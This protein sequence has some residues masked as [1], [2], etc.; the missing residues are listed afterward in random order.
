M[1]RKMALADIDDVMVIEEALFGEHWTKENF[2]YTL[3]EDPYSDI[4]LFYREGVIIG[5]VGLSILYERCEI[6]TL[7]VRTDYQGK[8]YGK[9]LLTY[10]ID[11]AKDRECEVAALE[12][13]VDNTVA[14]SLY[15]GFGFVTV[16][17]RHHYYSDGTDAYEMAKGI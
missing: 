3:Q 8:G 6:T 14:L 7:A 4:Y 2:R 16:R 5:Y 12:V 17:T 15:V 9:K 1:I 13:R 10:A 11:I